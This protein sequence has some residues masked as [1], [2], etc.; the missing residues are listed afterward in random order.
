MKSRKG[1][2]GGGE[3]QN[4]TRLTVILFVADR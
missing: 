3:K 4:K 2:G 1:R